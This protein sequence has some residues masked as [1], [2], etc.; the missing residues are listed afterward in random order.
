VGWIKFTSA[1]QA[2]P[3]IRMRPESTAKR[4]GRP[5]SYVVARR[6]QRPHQG[7]LIVFDDGS[8]VPVADAKA[9]GWL[10][11]SKE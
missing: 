11:E 6:E 3:G 7:N 4:P 9:F 5:R 8:Q 2:I 10:V 1:A